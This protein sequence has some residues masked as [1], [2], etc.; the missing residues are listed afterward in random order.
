MRH[1]PLRLPPSKTLFALAVAD[2]A[3]DD[4]ADAADGGGGGGAAVVDVAAAEAAATGAPSVVGEAVAVAPRPLGASL[5]AVGGPTPLLLLV[6]HA[7]DEGCVIAALRLLR[8]CVLFQP[9][10][11]RQFEAG[12]GWARLQGGAG[13]GGR[14]GRERG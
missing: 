2:A 9:A 8:S 5:G 7:A 6:R 11:S 10:N 12:R 3:D 4:G 13:C 14:G 1:G